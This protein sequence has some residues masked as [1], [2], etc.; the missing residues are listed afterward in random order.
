MRLCMYL[1]LIPKSR[2]LGKE[3]E[4]EARGS[5][6]RLAP[7]R[8]SREDWDSSQLLIPPNL[9]LRRWGSLKEELSSYLAQSQESWR[10]DQLGCLLVP[11]M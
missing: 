3:C 2:H 8:V 6:D 4:W 10:I 5:K 11:M 9:Q 7:V 1:V